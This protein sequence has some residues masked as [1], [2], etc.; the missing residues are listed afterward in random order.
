[1]VLLLLSVSKE[2]VVEMWQDEGH[3]VGKR[4]QRQVRRQ[5]QMWGRK[6]VR[7][8]E[9]GEPMNEEK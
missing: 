7:K 3:G 2:N 5:G 4:K 6:P 8:K 1:M 9:K